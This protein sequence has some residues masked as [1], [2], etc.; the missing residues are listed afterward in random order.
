MKESYDQGPANQIVPESCGLA[1]KGLAEALTGVRAG[2]VIESRKH[3]PGADALLAVRKATPAGS[4]RR[5]PA[6]PGGAARTHAR[7]DA[8]R[9]CGFVTAGREGQAFPSEAGRSLLRPGHAA[10]SAS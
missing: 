8:P 5:E 6:G 9:V 1:P 3:F 2:W 7:T 4:S 10:G